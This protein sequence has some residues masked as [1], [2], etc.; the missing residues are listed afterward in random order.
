MRLSKGKGIT[1]KNRPRD[2]KSPFRTKYIP[3]TTLPR[4]KKP[5]LLLPPRP[6]TIAAVRWDVFCRSAASNEAYCLR[7]KN[8]CV[9]RS[10]GSGEIKGPERNGAFP[11]N[12]PVLLRSPFYSRRVYGPQISFSD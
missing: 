6:H 3:A 8:E 7:T 4:Y 10:I 1:S 9:K 11:E 2:N 5:D 12:D